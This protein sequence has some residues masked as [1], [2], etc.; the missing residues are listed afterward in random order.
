MEYG[1]L[2]E[3]DPLKASGTIQRCDIGEVCRVML[4]KVCHVRAGFEV[5]RVLFLK[6]WSVSQLISYSLQDVGLSAPLPACYH[7]PQ[8]NGLISETTSKPPQL[9]F[10]VLTLSIFPTCPP[11]FPYLLIGNIKMTELAQKPP[12]KDIS[13]DC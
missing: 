5:L 10:L 6:L 12:I 9:I 11:L 8:H 1:G 13:L 3:N 2:E 7:A 4:E